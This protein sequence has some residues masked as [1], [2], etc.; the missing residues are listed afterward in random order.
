M[1][2]GEDKMPKN[3]KDRRRKKSCAHHYNPPLKDNHAPL[4]AGKYKKALGEQTKRL[5]DSWA[6]V[7]M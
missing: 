6:K 3:D 1:L 7:E 5:P 4:Y 2:F